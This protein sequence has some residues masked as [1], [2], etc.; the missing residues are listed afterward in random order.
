M[1]RAHTWGYLALWLIARMGRVV[2]VPGVGVVVSDSKVMREVLMDQ[3]SFLKTGPGSSEQLWTP[4]L[5]TSGLVN[6]DGP[7][8][9]ELRKQL[10]PLFSPK[11]ITQLVEQI[12]QPELKRIEKTLLAGEVVDL[13]REIEICAGR[14]VCVLAGFELS[15]LGEEDV[16]QQLGRARALLAQVSLTRR[17]FSP[18]QIEYALRNLS[19]LHI[20]IRSAYQ[21][22]DSRTVPG[23]MRQQGLDES[24]AV[25]VVTAMIVAG[26]ETIVSHLPRMVNLLYESGHFSKLVES[27]SDIDQVINESFRVTVPSPVMVRSVA[28]ETMVG[29]RVVTPGT[30]L[31]LANHQACQRAGRFNP[32]RPIPTE[33]RQIWFGAGPHFCIGMPIAQLQSRMFLESLLR[34][35]RERPFRIIRRK[36]RGRTIAP[37]F[38]RLELACT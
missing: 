28:H 31:I 13:A 33:M 23:F 38:L 32:A 17:E 8:H 30:R 14:L 9:H 27:D 2:R 7:D 36:Y 12:T 37:G 16:L 24:A 22:G 15:T 11:R 29:A 10:M 5:G 19:E 21:V 1:A 18:K 3:K 25:G 6:M 20:R 26:T 34:V 4:V 35:F